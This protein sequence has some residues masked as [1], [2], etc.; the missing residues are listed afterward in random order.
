MDRLDQEK[1]EL[2]KSLRAKR[3]E[4]RA[5]WAEAHRDAS[6]E[7]VMR[8]HLTRAGLWRDEAIVGVFLPIRSELDPVAMV[9][10]RARAIA[11]PV[12][13]EKDAPL[14]FRIWQDGDPLVA[15]AWGIRE[16]EATAPECAPDIV[17]VPLLGVDRQGYRI[18]YGGGFYDR[19]LAKLR[20]ANT[21][22]LAVGIGYDE[23]IVDSVP[24]GP[25]DEPV[26]AILTPAG[27]T[28]VAPARN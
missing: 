19:T 2:R 5:N 7:D 24:R 15:R 23:Q 8:E 26:D 28:M 10:G 16:P 6:A 20:A 17:I 18:G 3:A 12:M 14:A 11:L 4:A 22:L 27:L 21:K 1:A 25:Y 13:V 9:R